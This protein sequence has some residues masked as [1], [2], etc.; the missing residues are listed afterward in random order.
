MIRFMQRFPTPRR[1]SAALRT[2]AL[3]AAVALTVG[4]PA[5]AHEWNR[6][7]WRDHER[8]DWRQRDWREH[9]WRQRDWREHDWRGRPAFWGYGYGYSYSLPYN[10]GWSYGR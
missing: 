6:D 5:M 3:A 1:W 8:H 4:G 7:G 9:D 2:A 10:Y